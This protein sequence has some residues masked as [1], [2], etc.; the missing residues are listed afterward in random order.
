M[1]CSLICVKIQTIKC[2]NVYTEC[3]AGYYGNEANCSVCLG[4]T[5]KQS[6]GDASECDTECDH[7]SEP[8][9]ERTA[10]GGQHWPF[11]INISW[12][13]TLQKM[14]TCILIRYLIQFIIYYVECAADYYGNETSCNACTVNTIKP[15]QGDAS[16]CDTECDNRS[17]PNDEHT[18]CGRQHL[19][20]HMRCSIKWINIGHNFLFELSGSTLEIKKR[21]YYVL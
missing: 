1:Q 15:S 21:F 17:E 4:N 9:D 14:F 3:K 7:G 13:S 2:Y 19:S 12:L 16:E 18:T 11:E 6:Q 20:V 8:N 5:I 10:C